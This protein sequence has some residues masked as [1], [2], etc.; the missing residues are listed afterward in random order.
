[1]AAPLHERIE[2]AQAEVLQNIE[3]LK[4]LGHK[5]RKS[6]VVEELERVTKLGDLDQEVALLQEHMAR[7]RERHG[8]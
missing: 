1:M 7:A 4:R 5:R 3:K 8:L 6:E 2:D